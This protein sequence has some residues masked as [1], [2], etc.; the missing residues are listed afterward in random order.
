MKRFI[1]VYG[2]GSGSV[3][4]PDLNISQKNA[5]HATQFAQKVEGMVSFKNIFVTNLLVAEQ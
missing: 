3:R 5:R 4:H 2:S 1:R